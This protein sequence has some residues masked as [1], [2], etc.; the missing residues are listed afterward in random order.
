MTSKKFTFNGTEYGVVSN[1]LKIQNIASPLLAK[2]TKLTA[3]YTSDVDMSAVNSY[4]NRLKAI[5]NKDKA[6]KDYLKQLKEEKNE[7]DV[8]RVERIIE[9]NTVEKETILEDYKKD[10]KAQ[11][12]AKLYQTMEALA[13]QEAITDE[14]SIFPFLE[15]YLTG[16]ITKLD[17]DNPAILP[18]IEEVMTDF[19][20]S[21][22]L[23]D[24]V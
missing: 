14:D 9:K 2:L 8:A 5:E 4:R 1:V 6:D 13:I 23:K 18:F 22:V 16:D 15:K 10:L 7:K 24:N 12:N 3:Q 17:R 11:E 20:L 19:F 21:I